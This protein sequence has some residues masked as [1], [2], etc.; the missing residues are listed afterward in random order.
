MSTGSDGRSTQERELAIK[1][2]VSKAVISTD[3]ID[4]MEA[5]GIG[6]PDI[7]ILS[8]AFLQEVREMPQRNLAIEALKKLLEG[9]YAAERAPTSRKP[10]PSHNGWNRLSPATMPM[11]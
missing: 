4:I 6:K 7:S 5:A 3:I 2:L 9:R 10:K 11:P 8:D 1:Q